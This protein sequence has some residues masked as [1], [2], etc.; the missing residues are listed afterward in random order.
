MH[1]PLRVPLTALWVILDVHEV[2][3]L[4]LLLLFIKMDHLV[5]SIFLRRNFI[6]KSCYLKH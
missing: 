5:S 2:N 4:V 6:F 3:G 1:F